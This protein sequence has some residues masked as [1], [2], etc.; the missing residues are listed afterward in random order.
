MCKNARPT[1]FRIHVLFKRFKGVS[2][3]YTKT[4]MQQSEL[5]PFS[6]LFRATQYKRQHSHKYTLRVFKLTKTAV[7]ISR[8]LWYVLT[9]RTVCWLWPKTNNFST[10]RKI[11]PPISRLRTEFRDNTTKKRGDIEWE[12]KMVHMHR[13]KA[14]EI[15]SSTTEM[16]NGLR[17]DIRFS[18]DTRSMT[19]RT[20]FEWNWWN[21]QREFGYYNIPV[22][23]EIPANLWNWTPSH[24]E[25]P[26]RSQETTDYHKELEL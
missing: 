26:F 8:I 17:F 21:F 9:Y 22:E 16:S 7:P 14:Y 2:Y 1:D 25:T 4:T 15:N 20:N 3:R 12:N 18:V 6:I 23:G 11:V 19:I 24:A 13:R 5:I 10:N